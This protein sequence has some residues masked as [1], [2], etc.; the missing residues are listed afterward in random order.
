L[1][2]PSPAKTEPTASPGTTVTQATQPTPAPAE[3]RP[4]YKKGWFWGVVGGVV[5]VGVV[6][7][8][9]AAGTFSKSDPCSGRVCV[10]LG[11]MR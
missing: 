6:G 11:D 7:A 1:P 3:E 8:L 9:F 10:N 5:V 4:F 2:T